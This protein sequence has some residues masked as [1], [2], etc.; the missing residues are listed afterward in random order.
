VGTIGLIR[1]SKKYNQDRGVKFITYATY[2]IDAERFS[3][4]YARD[5]IR[6]PIHMQKYKKILGAGSSGSLRDVMRDLRVGEKTAQSVLKTYNTHLPFHLHSAP[7]D[8]ELKITFR[9][10]LTLS[11]TIETFL[12]LLNKK[13]VLI[14]HM[15]YD[16][17]LSFR[18]IGMR[19]GCSHETA[20][21]KDKETMKKM[22]IYLARC[23]ILPP[24]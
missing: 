14:F 12:G 7:P 11:S 10:L 18:D 13:D 24:L 17:E 3:L 2:W 15:R 6:I 20:R 23:S 19:M 9:D 5:M 22:L 8:K 16:E 1:A 4:V 21:K